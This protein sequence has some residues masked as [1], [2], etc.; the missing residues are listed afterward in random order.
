M[1]SG[2]FFGGSLAAAVVAGV[3]ALA[4][5]C[6]L[7]VMLPAYFANSFQ[8]R[9]LLVAMTFLFAGGVAT[10]ILPLALGAS[11]LRRVIVGEHTT[12][13]V[14]GGL[15]L[16]G[17]AV[18]TLAGG[19]LRLPAPG[20]RAGRPA[21]PLSVY[22]L[23]VFSGMAS[24]CCA[25]VLA[26]VVTLSGVASS[27]VRS[28]SLGL[29]Y[30]AGMV[31]PLFVISLLWD[32]VDWRTSPLFRPRSITWRLGPVRRQIT[33]TAMASA[34]LLA[35]MGVAAVWIG[36]A[37]EAMPAPSGWQARLAIWLQDLG[38]TVTDA[39]DWVPGWLTSAVLVAG[40]AALARIAAGQLGWTTATPD[41]D[42]KEEDEDG[43][44]I[45]A[46]HLDEHA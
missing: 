36:L 9:R 43:L 24:S 27:F 46:R 17:L 15:V 26:G 12:I 6:C 32:R 34:V 20:R 14:A 4:A 7:S 18:Y 25:P 31:A 1:D 8:N 23:G 11:A 42:E 29:A 44:A 21:G 41:P 5:P 40:V 39:V 37:G 30:V 13:Y 45:A 28:L 19:E 35:G 3:V 33:G 38:R 2:I 10:I 22:S 16:I